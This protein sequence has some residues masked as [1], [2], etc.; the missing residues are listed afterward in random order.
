MDSL[1]L[2]AIEARLS[3]SLATP[4]ETRAL[5]AEVRRLRA[6]IPSWAA[7]ERVE[8][9]YKEGLLA[10]GNSLIAK[11]ATIKELWQIIRAKERES[12]GAAN[13]LDVQEL[14]ARCA[15]LALQLDAAREPAR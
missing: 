10:I 15:D 13:S 14:D 4:S 6:E 3:L 11:D 8:G 9:F 1:D 5:I 12:Y 7:Y 2:D